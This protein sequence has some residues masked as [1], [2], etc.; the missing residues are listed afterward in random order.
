MVLLLPVVEYVVIL[1]EVLTQAKLVRG[2][3][4]RLIREGS[5]QVPKA[6]VTVLFLEQI[7]DLGVKFKVI[8]LQQVEAVS[9]VSIRA[10]L[11]LDI[12]HAIKVC[13]LAPTCV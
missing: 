13:S 12:R 6:V 8:W 5:V 4:V 10:E 3:D 1:D 9:A 11:K 2:I 7:V